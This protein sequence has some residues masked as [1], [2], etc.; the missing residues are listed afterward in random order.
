[1]INPA[2]EGPLAED[3]PVTVNGYVLEVPVLF[4]TKDI[5]ILNFKVVLMAVQSTASANT[6]VPKCFNGISV[7]SNAEIQ[8]KS[9]LNFHKESA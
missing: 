7:T 9:V 4:T 3:K 1:M 6:T 8:L 5:Y 2:E